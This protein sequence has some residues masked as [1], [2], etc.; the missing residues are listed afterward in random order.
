M[1]GER[2]RNFRKNQC[3]EPGL[4]WGG[5]GSHTESPLS[6]PRR[7]RPQAGSHCS[8]SLE[9]RPLDLTLALACPCSGAPAVARGVLSPP[10]L[11]PGQE[12]V[13]FLPCLLIPRYWNPAPEILF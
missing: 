3:S 2:R 13:V 4:G 1:G 11:P 6:A 9:T 7:A 12:G 10:D 5:R 8:L